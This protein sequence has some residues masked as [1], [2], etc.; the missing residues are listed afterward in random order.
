MFDKFFDW[1]ERNP[2]HAIV[3]VMLMLVILLSSLLYCITANAQ[4]LTFNPPGAQG[5]DQTY[6]EIA[7]YVVK[8]GGSH[9]LCW[10]NPNVKADGTEVTNLQVAWQRYRIEGG[11]TETSAVLTF[12]QWK[13]TAVVRQY[14]NTVDAPK[15]AGHWAYSMRMCYWPLS[16]ENSG[17]S[18]WVSGIVPNSASGGGGTVDDRPKGWWVYAYIPAPTGVGVD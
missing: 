7:T 8:V 17:C 12:P 9:Q 3:A 2:L 1:Y 16:S 6:T 11:A 4:T 13:P 14:C 18:V 5:V 10:T 15:K